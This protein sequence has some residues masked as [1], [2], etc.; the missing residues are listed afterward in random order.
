VPPRLRG[1]RFCADSTCH[2]SPQP[3]VTLRRRRAAESTG[4]AGSIAP[5]ASGWTAVRAYRQRGEG[6]ADLG[7]DAAHAPGRARSGAGNA[8]PNCRGESAADGCR[9]PATALSVHAT[10]RHARNGQA[11]AV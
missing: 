2:F 6:V 11:A 10:A 3:S 9:P 5:A 7:A 8:R 4:E 1:H